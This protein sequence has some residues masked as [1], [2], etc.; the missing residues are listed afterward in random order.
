MGGFGGHGKGL[1]KI[2]IG[3][4]YSTITPP[5]ILKISISFL[6]PTYDLFIPHAFIKY[7]L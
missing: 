5:V 6:C 3:D 2:G 1:D 7:H 4:Y